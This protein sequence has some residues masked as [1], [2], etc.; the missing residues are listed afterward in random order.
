MAAKGV[1]PAYRIQT[2]RLVVRCWDPR[3]AAMLK[4]AIDA[5][6]DHLRPWMDWAQ[7][8]PRPLEPKIEMLRRARAQ[9]DLNQDYP[10]GI[11][12]PEETRV[13]GG[14]GLHTRIGIGALEI[15]YWIDQ[16][17]INQGLAT[18]AA[19]ALTRVAF[20]VEEVRRVEIHCD[21]NNVRSARIPKKLGFTLEVVRRKFLYQG[22]DRFRDTMIWTL[23]DSEYPSSHSAGVSIEAFDVIGRKLV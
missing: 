22:G 12:N 21:P 7:D 5:N 1:G 20:E 4:K 13:I 11:F 8:E 15:G 19:A 17:F 6:L 3:D 23:L 2:S 14:G 9:F 18:E 16:E 10:F